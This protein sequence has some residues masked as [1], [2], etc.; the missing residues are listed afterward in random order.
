MLLI[1]IEVFSRLRLL[2]VFFN[3]VLQVFLYMPHHTTHTCTHTYNEISIHWRHMSPFCS[4]AQSCPTLSDPMDGS[5]PGFP[6]LHHLLELAQ[7]HVHRVSDAIQP[8]CPLSSPSPPAL[9]LSQ[10]GLF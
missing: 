4:A 3:I 2:T 1:N 8:S 9:N 6:I 7:T 5:T 10:Q